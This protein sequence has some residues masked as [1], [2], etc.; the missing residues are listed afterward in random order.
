MQNGGG[1]STTLALAALFQNP[2]FI[3]ALAA[4]ASTPPTR[5]NG[6]TLGSSTAP[7][8]STAGH[9]DDRALKT[10]LPNLFSAL[11]SGSG[12]NTHTPFQQT[13][14]GRIS[15]PPVN[16]PQYSL[17]QALAAEAD[18]PNFDSLLEAV[19]SGNKAKVS[20]SE[21][22]VGALGGL[23]GESAV[24]PRNG[25]G[26]IYKTKRDERADLWGLAKDGESG[27]D[28]WTAQT[29][30][31]AQNRATS[32][33]HRPLE[34]STGDEGDGE[35]EERELP[36]WPLPPS[37]PGG[38]KGMPRDEMLARRRARNRVAA[39]ASRRKKR[40][41]VGGLEGRLREKESEYHALEAHCQTL[42][43]Q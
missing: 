16:P 20:G 25:M 8:I 10:K 40:E 27:G 23:G 13:R 38:R 39:I 28:S 4:S 6:A 36:Q 7:E 35:D 12:T 19:S 26:M 9:N 24:G 1:D 30:A 15:R 41:F 11:E 31:D 14:S 17:L 22:G 18:T 2:I 29:L 32:K 21:P 37:G 3:K 43:Q 42:E 33:R 34:L 5:N